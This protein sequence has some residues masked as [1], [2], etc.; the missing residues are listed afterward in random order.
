MRTEKRMRENNRFCY[1]LGEG[2]I[3]KRI[4]NIVHITQLLIIPSVKAFWKPM[5]TPIFDLCRRCL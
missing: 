5:R 4:Y 2:K 1:V 3:N